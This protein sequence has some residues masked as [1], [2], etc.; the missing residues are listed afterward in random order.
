[1]RQAVRHCSSKPSVG[2]SCVN[3]QN[4]TGRIHTKCSQGWLVRS[5]FFTSY[6]FNSSVLFEFFSKR[7][8]C[9]IYDLK[10]KTVDFNS[11]VST[12]H[13]SIF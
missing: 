3:V 12:H 5:L 9:N 6:T 7:T 4:K 11:L 10:Q 13:L 1:M 2:A 8:L